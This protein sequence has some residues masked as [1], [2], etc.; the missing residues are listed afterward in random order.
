MAAPPSEELLARLDALP[1]M[2]RLQGALD[3]LAPAYLVGGA[4]RDLI[5]GAPATD[6][7]L[8]VEGDSQEFAREL[9]QRLGGQAVVHDR[10]GTATVRAE[11]VAVDLA[12]TRRERYEAPGALPAV[13]PAGL[14]EDLRRRDFTVNAMALALAPGERGRLHD[15][16]GGAEDLAA[17]RLRVLHARSFLDDPTRILR[18]LRYAARLGLELEPETER[19]LRQ[20]VADGALSTVSAPRVRDEL[21]DLLAEPEM[22]AALERMGE[23][24]VTAAMSP[25]L[26]GELELAAAAALGSAETGADPALAALAALCSADPEGTAAFVA[27][28]GLESRRRDAVLG[29]AERAPAVARALREPMR[30][31]ALHALLT[32]EPPETLALA[33][34]MG[35]PGEPVTRFLA[36]LRPARLQIGGADLLAAGLPESP[37]IGDALAE[38]LRRKL[39]GEISGR[40]E[41][42]ASALELA[43]AAS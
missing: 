9:A 30:P 40:D 20:A 11:G 29:A 1:G 36:D 21:L 28:L 23:L 43:R 18:A 42:L 12:R 27:G 8:A 6:V 41:E 15:P 38:T 4:V 39:D 13:E 2:D 24:G 35:A 14:E 16:A 5:R 3:G 25:A 33:L 26:G 31:S 7:D 17:G 34:G 19:L 22:P 37:A 32:P 10:F